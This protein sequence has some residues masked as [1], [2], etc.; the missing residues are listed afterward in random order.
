V[1]AVAGFL[2]FSALDAFLHRQAFAHRDHD[3]A[4]DDHDHE[5]GAESALG[6]VGP[7]GLIVHSTLDGLAI[8]LAFRASAEVGLLVA[9]AVLA[10]DFADGMNVVTLALARGGRNSAARA[11]LVVDALAPPIGA[12][13]GTV[14]HLENAH[15]GLLLAVFAGV[16]VA[17]GSGHLLPEAYHG[18][19]GASPQLIVLTTA[20]AAIVLGVR[21]VLG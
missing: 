21:W 2:V 3:H 17:I 12:A 18:R 6:V 16:F 9:F 20:G 10:H 1:A 5:H 13:I 14:A 8:G 19:P 15:L 11:L 7:A 4:H